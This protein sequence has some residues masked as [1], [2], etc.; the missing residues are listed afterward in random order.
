MVV[1]LTVLEDALQQVLAIGSG[2][3]G[4]HV[5]PRKEYLQPKGT[6]EGDAFLTFLL[7]SA[8]PTGSAYQVPDPNPDPEEDENERTVRESSVQTYSSFW[9][10]QAHRKGAFDIIHHLHVWMYSPLAGLELEKRGLVFASASDIRDLSAILETAYEDRYSF[11]MTIG[12]QDQTPVQDLGRI[13]QVTIGLRF[14]DPLDV[15][16]IVVSRDDP[17]KGVNRPPAE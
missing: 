3:N 2:L 17:P 7:M 15:R 16:T 4:T 9:S 12:Y 6:R 1:E 8:D 14:E 10:I 11:D 5:I 13:D